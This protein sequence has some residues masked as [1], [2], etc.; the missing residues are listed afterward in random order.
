MTVSTMAGHCSQS[1][2]SKTSTCYGA[3]AWKARL[4]RGHQA[5]LG[6]PGSR[7]THVVP[8]C[9]DDHRVGGRP[10]GACAGL[11]RSATSERPRGQ[12]EAETRP[13]SE[14]STESGHSRISLSPL[15]AGITMP[16]IA[17]LNLAKSLQ[18]STFGQGQRFKPR[19]LSFFQRTYANQ[20]EQLHD[21]AFFT[22]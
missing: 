6:K 11:S 19:D 9:V 17:F 15:W 22:P 20:N 5:A 8:A 21:S 18:L 16:I 7:T 14:V 4:R 3:R 12:S 13:P 2:R 1:I 10:D